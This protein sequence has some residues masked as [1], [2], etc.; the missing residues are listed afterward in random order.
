MAMFCAYPEE[1][2]LESASHLRGY[3]YDGLTGA[4]VPG[5]IAYAIE[6]LP[7]N[8]LGDTVACDFTLPMDGSYHFAGLPDGDY[9]VAIHALDGSSAVGYI[10]PGNI[11]QLIYEEAVTLLVPEYWDAAESSTDDSAQR[12]PISVMAGATAVADIF[13][14]IDDVGPTVVAVSPLDGAVDALVSSAILVRFSEAVDGDSFGG[15]FNFNPA[16]GGA[17]VPGSAS[18]VQDDH[19]LMYV[20]SANLEFETTYEV[21]IGGGVQDLFGNPMGVSFPFSFTT[22]VKPP[23]SI[24]Y[25]APSKGIGGALIVV[26]GEGFGVESNPATVTIGEVSAEVLEWASDRLLVAVPLVLPP[27]PVDLVVNDPVSGG[28]ATTLFTVL[29]VADA[30]RGLEIG[31]VDLPGLPRMVEVSPDGK[32]SFV[33]TDAGLAVID[34]TVPASPQLIFLP[35]DGGLNDLDVSPDGHAVFAVSRTTEKLYRYQYDT[36]VVPPGS[37]VTLANEILLPE[38][39]L[40]IEVHPSGKK[41]Y[42][43]TLAEIQ[44]WDI[45]SSSATF[46]NQIGSLTGAGPGL[47][48]PT[49]IDPSGNI[50]LAVTGAGEVA[51]FDLTTVAMSARV[52]VQTSPSDVQVDPTGN[53]AYV[54]DD[55]GYL[56]VIDLE[57]F[58]KV[59]DVA[60]GGALKGAAV[61]PTA[62]FIYATNHQNDDLDVIDLRAGSATFH[63]LATRIPSRINPVDIAFSPG[64]LYAFSLVEFERKFVITAVGAGPLLASLIPAAGPPGAKVVLSGSGFEGSTVSFNGDLIPVERS[65]DSYFAVTIPD[66]AVTG[67]V[68]VVGPSSGEVSNSLVFEVLSPDAG[69]MLNNVGVVEPDEKPD[70]GNALAVVPGGNVVLVGGEDGV[71][72][73]LNTDPGSPAY[74]QFVAA[75]SVFPAAISGLAVAVDA[76][77]AYVG[78]QTSGEIRIVDVNPAN[79]TFG[80]LVGTIDLGVSGS[81]ALGASPDGGYLLAAHPAGAEVLV[82]ELATETVMSTPVPQGQL[83]GIVFHPGGSHAYLNVD[84]DSPAVVV[85]LDMNPP[86]ETFGTVVGEVSLPAGTPDEVPVSLSFAPDGDLCYILTS[87]LKTTPNRSLVTLD[88]SVPGVPTNPVVLG[89]I[90][91]ASAPLAEHL[92]VSPVG[93]R[94]VFNIRTDGLFQLQLDP[95]DLPTGP[96]VA[97]GSEALAFAFSTDGSHLY[98]ADQQDDSVHIFDFA[99]DRQIVPVWGDDQTGVAGETLAS[100]LRVRVIDEMGEPLEAAAVTFDVVT[101]GGEVF[102]DSPPA[103]GASL[104]IATDE[105]GFAQVNWTLGPGLG[106]QKVL[107]SSPGAAGSPVMFNATA[108]EDPELL[109]LELV[110][111][112]FAPLD[113]STDVSVTTVVRATFT[114]PVDPVSIHEDSYFLWDQSTAAKV[115]TVTGFASSERVVSLTPVSELEYGTD[116]TVVVGSDIL[117]ASGGALV[118]PTEINF[119]T[120]APPAAPTLSSVSPP[121]AITFVNIVLSGAGFDPVPANNQVFFVNGETGEE[122]PAYVADGATNYL[123]VTIPSGAET[124]TVYV[125]NASGASNELPFVVLVESTIVEDDIIGRATTGSPS[126][127]AT[128]SPDGA[129]AY[130]ISPEADLVIPVDLN[131]LVTLPSIPVGDEPWAIDMHPAGTFVYVANRLSGDVSVID[132]LAGSANQHDVVAT[133]EVGTEP[134]DIVV[135]PTGDRVYVAN[136]LSEDMNI[137][138][139]DE[140]SA[141]FHNVIGRTSTGSGARSMTVSPD[142]TRLYVGTDDG[143]IVI[144]TLDF[145]VIGRVSTGAGTRRVTVSPDGAL[146]VLI[147]FSGDVFL[148][149]ITP[150]SDSENQVIGRVTTGSGAK[151]ATVSPDGAL[152]FVV[153]E[154]D[155]T[156][157]VYDIDVGSSIGVV[158][159]PGL[160]VMELELVDTLHPGENPEVVAFFPDGSGR[161]LVTNSGD[162]TV[163]V[164]GPGGVG[165]ISGRVFADC[166]EPDTGLYGVKID[167]FANESGDLVTTFITDASGYYEGELPAGQYN[168]TILTPLSYLI[169]DEVQNVALSGAAPV[170]LDWSL[171]C[172]DIVPSQRPMSYWKHQV[173]S[174]IRED[175]SGEI[176]AETLCYYLDAIDGH[177][178][179]GINTVIIYDPPESDDCMD[180]LMVA[181]DLL[182][183][184]GAQGHLARAK[185]QALAVLFN[186]AS[187]RV[188]IQEVVSEDGATMSQAITYLDMLIDDELTRNDQRAM[189]IG[190]LLNRG[191]TV[192][193]G[194]IPTD[195]PDISYLPRAGTNRLEQNFPNPFNPTA[196]IRFEINRPQHVRLKVYDISGRLVR[197]LVDEPRK[198]NTY[199]VIWDGTDDRGG[200]VASGVYFYKMTAGSFTQTRKMMLL[201]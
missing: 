131:T 45:N 6:A 187:G 107:A 60:A 21:E 150:G 63:G 14:N 154:E 68:T 198:A 116:Y 120:E 129:M 143:Y 126:R 197:T 103:N 106:G 70:F 18:L 115:P 42:V 104:T 90:P 65:G 46:E 181:K 109:P 175:Q 58:T 11:N 148:Y 2:A 38:V 123:E 201:K 28:S 44:I 48:G 102:L 74:R 192:P 43:T 158:D 56:S 108:V 186:V 89:T 62:S 34:V 71:L 87:Q 111:N 121:S 8:A 10:Q 96:D 119:T 160:P 39:P 32:L 164:Y 27:G 178:N 77:V 4:P 20:P 51:A 26:N 127:N 88:T 9:F 195:L 75:A 132:V 169:E 17:F 124:G 53:W 165:L 35:V 135:S 157:L 79:P 7:G 118:N 144:G 99:G 155:D 174:A 84:A 152:L 1:S 184:W 95:V 153:T 3:V 19:T 80:D 177:F 83:N 180:K 200:P 105:F 190:V 24:T 117:D 72:H 113:G 171:Q 33:A 54:T 50:L 137:I 191:W 59:T 61:T 92:R 66:M 145:G 55:T 168:A 183:L 156:V 162:N 64:G 22:E 199:V 194:W 140:T 189:F 52:L 138:D 172:E 76:S 40:G 110:E 151:S 57:S 159:G 12:T 41:A 97:L 23:V 94:A 141:A 134:V 49:A 149:D 29:E 130:A 167:M 161:F 182:N 101:G 93:D 86:S 133:L 142:G 5:V 114:R 166:P 73:L 170:T 78:S 188:S 31:T 176:D 85:L 146:L 15:Q 30:A 16:G 82:V 81:G 185:Q 112:L 69:G 136:L 47:L 196:S 13:T 36:S 125:S 67:P 100:P 193:S 91:S 139:A 98:V 163:T 179:H 147:D 173:G 122:T 128:I 25:L 37:S